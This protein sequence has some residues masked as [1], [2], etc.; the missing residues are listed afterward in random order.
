MRILVAHVDS[1]RLDL[2]Q[3]PLYEK[4]ELAF[5]KTHYYGGIKKYQWLTIPLALHGVVVKADGTKINI[6]I[7][8]KDTDPVFL[9]HR[10]SAAPFAGAGQKDN[11]RR[12]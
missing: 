8:E 12:L 7:G 9:Y 3:V 1:P 5:L 2:K 6:K 4:S 10:P 11:R